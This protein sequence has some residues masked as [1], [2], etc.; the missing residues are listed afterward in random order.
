MNTIILSLYVYLISFNVFA[1]LDSTARTATK[2]IQSLGQL[3][4][5][6]FIVI[7]G[8]YY[9]TGSP[10]ARDKAKNLMIGSLLILGGQSILTFLK[11]AIK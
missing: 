4:I 7:A 8:Y 9:V 11:S 3:V 2:E 5:G 6:V 10:E 1:S